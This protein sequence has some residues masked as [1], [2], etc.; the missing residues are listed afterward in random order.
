MAKHGGDILQK[1]VH[2]H[3]DL[4]LIA[5]DLLQRPFRGLHVHAG[6]GAKVAERLRLRAVP[7]GCPLRLVAPLCEDLFWKLRFDICAS[8]RLSTSVAPATA[9]CHPSLELV[10]GWTASQH[11]AHIRSCGRRT[12]KGTC[13]CAPLVTRVNRTSPRF[14][15]ASPL[16]TSRS[17][18]VHMDRERYAFLICRSPARNGVVCARARVRSS[19][20]CQQC[21]SM[22][23][24]G[25][26]LAGDCTPS[27]AQGE[28]KTAYNLSMA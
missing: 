7:E 5:R 19:W 28:S 13:V 21:G 8:R 9:C 6:A 12:G 11:K 3:L 18:C 1:V 2:L 23:R 17:G 25:H 10:S 26:A 15:S 22:A 14:W 27:T 20:L 24:T 4:I 16:P